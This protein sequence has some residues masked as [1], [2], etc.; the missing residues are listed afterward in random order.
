MLYIIKIKNGLAIVQAKGYESSTSM[1]ESH[2]WQYM[3]EVTRIAKSEGV[4]VK[5]EIKEE[6]T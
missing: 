6:H 2:V 3:K 4:S 1:P 5:W